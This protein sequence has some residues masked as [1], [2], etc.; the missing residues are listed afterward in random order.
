MTVLD[1]REGQSIDNRGGEGNYK[2]VSVQDKL[3]QTA[4]R[5]I[6]VQPSATRLAYI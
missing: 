6:P 1:E 5:N 2:I 3:S 4:N